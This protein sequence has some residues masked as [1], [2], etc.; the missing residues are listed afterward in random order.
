MKKLLTIGLCIALLVS[1]SVSAFA[2]SSQEVFHASS[3][4][5]SEALSGA[6]L[7]RTEEKIESGMEYVIDTYEKTVE[8]ENRVLPSGQAAVDYQTTYYRAFREKGDQKPRTNNSTTSSDWDVTYSALFSVTVY[9]T[10]S[11]IGGYAYRQMTSAEGYCSVVDSQVSLYAHNL[12]VGEQGK[13]VNNNLVE[14]CMTYNLLTSSTSWSKTLS[15]SLFPAIRTILS[16][17]AVRYT[18]TLKRGANSIWSDDIKI[19]LLD[20][21]F[22]FD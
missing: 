18:I 13:G 4:D 15:A 3:E 6:V 22:T 2:M 7:I 12:M 19:D 11:T 20:V 14:E 10:D 1:S 16:S 17:Q 9:Y 21:L 8:L 5:I